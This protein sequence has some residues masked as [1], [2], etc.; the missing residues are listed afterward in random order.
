MDNILIYRLNYLGD[1]ILTTPNRRRGLQPLLPAD[2]PG[3]LVQKKAAQTGIE[4]LL[5]V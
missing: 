2:V 5:Q 1:V 4:Q 3:P